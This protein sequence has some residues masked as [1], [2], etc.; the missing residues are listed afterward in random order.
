MKK[1]ILILALVVTFLLSL[2]VSKARAQNG[3]INNVNYSA[4]LPPNCSATGTFG[5]P[6]VWFLISDWNGYT[7]GFYWCNDAGEWVNGSTGLKVN[8]SSTTNSTS[9]FIGNFN[10]TTPSIPAGDVPVHFQ[11]DSSNP[12]NISGYVAA[13]A[14]S[15]PYVQLNTNTFL[16]DSGLATS[17][18][19]NQQLGTCELSLL[20][21]GNT[22][23]CPFQLQA[24]STFLRVPYPSPGGYVYFGPVQG[25]EYHGGTTSPVNTCTGTGP[26]TCTQTFEV[27]HTGDALIVAMAIGDGGAA[28]NSLC[29]DSQSNTY[30]EIPDI[31]NPDFQYTSPVTAGSLTVTCSIDAYQ[32]TGNHSPGKWYIIEVQNFDGFDTPVSSG[33]LSSPTNNT[34][35]LTESVTTTIS[36]DSILGIISGAAANSPFC[37]TA[38]SMYTTPMLIFDSS[39][40]ARVPASDCANTLTQVG[41][42]GAAA[43]GTY[44]Q[45]AIIGGGSGMFANITLLPIKPANTSAPTAV[46]FWGNYTFA[47]MSNVGG[48]GGFLTGIENGGALMA[49]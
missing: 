21:Q 1:R 10:S 28:I 33:N 36:N 48:F 17:V 9:P 14:T 4:T 46:A 40:V 18:Y 23:Q 6:R 16:T 39:D 32:G 49:P 27:Q 19:Q 2:G 30:A 41:S 42:I 24:P 37:T 26:F 15:I 45:Q 11:F 8:G 3:A 22:A 7:A 29:N 25:V 44:T 31:G 20:P 38:T 34:T 43:T 47:D 13:S 5:Y 12:S 35:P